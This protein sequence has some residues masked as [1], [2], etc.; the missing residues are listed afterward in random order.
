MDIKIEKTAG[1]TVTITGSLPAEVFDSF[2]SKALSN[3][4]ETVTLDGF[5]KGNVPEKILVS[6]VGEMTVLEEMAELALRSTYPKIIIDNKIDA[7]GTPEIKIKKIAPGNP[8]EF[9]IITDVVPEI[10]L[11]DYKKISADAVSKKES[12]KEVTDSDLDEA[13]LRIRRSRADH[14]SHEHREGMTEEEHNRLTD[15]NLPELND[16]FVKS[17]GNFSEV[18]D[19]KMKIK[20]TLKNQRMDE[21]EE[22]LRVSISDKILEAT[23]VEVP[24]VMVSSE[25]RRIE[26]QFK[27]DIARMGISFDDYLKHAKKTIDEI[28]AEWEP[29]AKKKVQLQLILNEIAKKEKISPDPKEIETEVNHIVEHYKDA[30]RERAAIY[31][32]TVL[33][34]EK[35][36]KMLTKS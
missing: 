24:K 27:D 36:F 25:L 33:T 13:I 16:S 1:S 6:K 3:I 4:N 29:S 34:N 19:F 23:P 30:D 32:E 14:K 10:T 12:A 35:V 7:V 2:R 15:Q 11:P 31:A 8:L 18:S 20:E 21:I 28:R 9:E 22:K 26:A 17:L 5:R